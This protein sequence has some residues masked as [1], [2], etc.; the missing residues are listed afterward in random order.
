LA[1][2]GQDD[3]V[4]ISA[5]SDY[6]VRALL[7]LATEPHLVTGEELAARQDLPRKFLEAIL[8]DLR[9]AHL[10]R[11]RR[12]AQGGYQLE[13]H[14]SEITLGQVIRAVDGPL[15]LVRGEAPHAT[16]YAGVA[17]HLP[18]VWVALRAAVREVLDTTT[19]QDLATGELPDV[20]RRLAEAPDAWQQR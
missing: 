18:T 1:T 10:L 7:V 19:L 9:R 2:V 3:A 13:R 6:A 17:Q 5:R 20:V 4:Q 12:G 16:A 15:A 8:A 11:T 14:A